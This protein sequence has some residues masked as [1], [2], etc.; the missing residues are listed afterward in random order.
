M[1]KWVFFSRVILVVNVDTKQRLGCY[2]GSKI[3][4]RLSFAEEFSA[5]SWAQ[6]SE[7][8]I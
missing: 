6:V 2:D 3:I 1:S 4:A 8:V 7:R 5:R